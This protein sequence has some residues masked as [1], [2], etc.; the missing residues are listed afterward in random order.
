[1]DTWKEL[2]GK[3]VYIE[4]KSGRRYSGKVISYE[5]HFFKIIDKFGST[6]FISIDELNVIQ[7]E[8]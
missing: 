4:L 5:N 6:I 7:E 2:E 3:K 8:R 1:M